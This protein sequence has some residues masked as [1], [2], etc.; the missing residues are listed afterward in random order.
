MAAQKAEEHAFLLQPGVKP[1]KS[2]VYHYL[3]GVI[4]FRQKDYHRAVT[5][6]LKSDLSNYCV[7]FDLA[8]AYDQ[9]QEFEKAGELMKE[10]SGCAFI[11][12][13]QPQFVRSS[14]SYLK[15]LAMLP[16]E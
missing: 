15:R 8:L 6:F 5:H 4:S 14:Q 13:Y 9:L 7:K 1:G 16:E 10:V 2:Q 3:M 12:S 11:S